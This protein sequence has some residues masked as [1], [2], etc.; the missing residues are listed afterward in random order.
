MCDIPFVTTPPVVNV[1]RRA[2]SWWLL[3]LRRV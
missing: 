3:G 1:A 2:E